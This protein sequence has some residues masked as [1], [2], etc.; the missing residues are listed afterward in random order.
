[1]RVS[2]AQTPQPRPS[3]KEVFVDDGQVRVENL[4]SR[5]AGEDSALGS[6]IIRSISR[7]I[8]RKTKGRMK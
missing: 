8:I 4:H 6:H 2:W 7:T 3:W 5:A 1:M